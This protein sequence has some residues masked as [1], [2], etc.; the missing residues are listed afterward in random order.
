[1]LNPS[2]PVLYRAGAVLL[3]C[4]LLAGLSLAPCGCDRLL[5]PKTFSVMTYNLH[6]YALRDRDGD[7]AADDPKPPQSRAAAVQLIASRRPDV[8]AVQEMGGEITFSRFRN[9]LE[10][11]GADYPYAELLVNGREVE[12][13]LAVLSRFPI[14]ASRHHTNEYY[15][16]GPARVPVTRGFLEVDIQVTPSYRFRLINAHLKSK[17]YSPLGQTEMRRNEARLLNKLVRSILD[18]H[19]DINLLVAGDMNDDY[20]SAAL[21]EVK[22]RRGGKL[23]DLRPVDAGGDAWTCFQAST[24]SYSRFDYLFV[25]S[26]M[27][28]EVV[29]EKTRAVRDPLMWNASDHRPIIAV[30]QPLEK[31]PPAVR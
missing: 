27:E 10:R 13:N 14:A 5:P 7:E 3:K 9:A 11:A 30:F 2:V 29:R 20:A 31:P 25:S 21:R 12:A 1:M 18:D 8:L 4:A 24:D 6:E 22:G 16:I 17:V 28:P 19:P 26:G 23:T 15:S